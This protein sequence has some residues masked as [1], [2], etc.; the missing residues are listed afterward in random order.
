MNKKLMNKELW[1][2]WLA[3]IVD[4]DGCFYINK[5]ENSISISYTCYFKNR[6]LWKQQ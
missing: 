4:G 6:K 5:K 1:N 2:E 3:G